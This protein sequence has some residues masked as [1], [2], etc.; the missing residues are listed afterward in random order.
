VCYIPFSIISS[1]KPLAT[2]GSALT[3]SSL[4][5]L[6]VFFKPDYARHPDAHIDKP[7]FHEH[8]KISGRAIHF[9]VRFDSWRALNARVSGELNDAGRRRGVNNEREFAEQW[10]TRNVTIPSNR[11]SRIKSEATPAWFKATDRA[12]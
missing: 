1:L 9:A 7:H 5:R 8:A 11:G 2:S 10:T 12:G 6:F 4:C 3:S